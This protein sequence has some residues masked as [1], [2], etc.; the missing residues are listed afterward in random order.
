[1][2]NEWISNEMKELTPAG[3]IKRPLYDVIAEWVQH[4]WDAIDPQLIK[5]SFKCCGI[6]VSSNGSEENLIFNN[7]ETNQLQQYFL[8]QQ[9]P[10]PQQFFL[11]QPSQQHLPFQHL[12]SQQHLF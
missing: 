5:C 10:L 11:S 1:M 4:S 3:Q 12:P 9:G 2:Y 6:S 7:D 8:L